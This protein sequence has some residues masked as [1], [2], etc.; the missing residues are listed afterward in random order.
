MDRRAATLTFLAVLPALVAPGCGDPVV[1]LGDAPGTMRVVVGIPDSIGSRLDA[2]AT[3]SRLTRPS[4]AAF[5]DAS[6]VLYVADQGSLYQAMG[7][8]T[9]AAR[10]LS[11]GSAGAIALLL[12]ASSCPQL[13][14]REI[15][16]LVLAPDG[17][18]LVADM[19]G[20][21]VY[22]FDPQSRALTAVAGTGELGSAPDGTPATQAALA[23]PAGVAVAADGTLFV[24]EAMN[25]RVRMISPGGTLQT[26]AGTGVDGDAGDGGPATAAQLA[27]P[28]GLTLRQGTLYIADSNNARVRAV[29]LGSG[30]ISAVAGSGVPGDEGDDGP[31]LEARLMRP[32]AVAITADGASLFV[33]DAD[34]NRV[35]RVNLTTGVITTFAGTGSALFAGDRRPAGETALAG[36][37]AVITSTLQFLFIVDSGHVVVWRTA[38]GF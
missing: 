7:I 37:T 18:L 4:A 26:V 24:S 22:R 15:T 33:A 34:A 2:Q 31:A 9:P 3:H 23:R 6:G 11:V 32:M 20:N 16:G 12:D 38:L 36:P 30:I 5:D 10:I 1:V 19:A 14:V 25:H 35:R 8:S 17:T 28:A 13:C 21:R 27:A 29:D